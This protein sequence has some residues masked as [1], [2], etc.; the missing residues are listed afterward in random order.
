MYAAQAV[1]AALFRR[2]RTGKGRLIEM[3]LYDSGITVTGYYG[4]DALQLGHDP[5]RYGNAHP[6]IVPYGMYESADGPLIIA[7]GNNSQFDKFCRLV[8][9]RPDIVE[10]QRFS[11][12]V[13]RARNRLE[14]LPM[15]KTL[16]GSFPRD[17]LLERLTAAGIPC[18]RVAGLHEALTSERTRRSG[19]LR[20]MP[21]PVAGT[22]PVF[23]PPYRLDGQ[24]LPIRHAPPTLGEGTREVLQRLLTL[25]DAQLQDLQSK[26][27][28]TLPQEPS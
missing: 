7:V 24:R 15:L 5:E 3:A 28:L 25:D 14:L 12:N 18:G 21:H 17:L 11:T 1:L 20:D 23:A 22:T 9:M 6:S 2:E 27:V 4:L 19:L 8:I 16:I 10:D 26:G 13:N